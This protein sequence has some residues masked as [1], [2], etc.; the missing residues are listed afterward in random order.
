MNIRQSL[1]FF[2]IYNRFID[3]AVH[4]VWKRFR[5]NLG[6]GVA[7]TFGSLGLCIPLDFV[8]LVFLCHSEFCR[9]GF[10]V[11]RDF[12]PL[13]DFVSPGNFIARMFVLL[14]FL[15]RSDFCVALVLVSL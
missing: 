10:F 1:L 7:R 11:A 5:L 6:F 15:C 13:E 8:L 2:S 12:F 3:V 14:G 9:L 4:F